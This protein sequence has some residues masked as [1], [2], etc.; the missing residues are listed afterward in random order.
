MRP[1]IA[2]SLAVILLFAAAVL[3]ESQQSAAA[4][5]NDLLIEARI[6]AERQEDNRVKVALELRRESADWTE[7]LQPQRRYLRADAPIDAWRYSEP[8]SP[9]DGVPGR[10]RIAAR[11]TLYGHVELALQRDLG[12][13]WGDLQLPRARQ[14]DSPRYG[15][16][17]FATSSIDLVDHG[18]Q[19]CRL[20][21]ILAPGDY[22]RFPDTRDLLV[23]QANGVARYPTSL[24]LPP[25]ARDDGRLA[26]GD[27]YPSAY[28]AVPF[29][30]GFPPGTTLQTVG[31][32][33]LGEGKYIIRR[34]G[35]DRLRP[36]NGAVCA[37]GLLIPFGH[38]CSVLAGYVW[39]V[40]YP[41]GPA[42]LTVPN[43][44]LHWISDTDLHAEVLPKHIDPHTVHAVR[45]TGGW[46]ITTLDAPLASSLPF[47]ATD[48][49]PCALG[50]IIAPGE[51]CS[52]P[53]SPSTFS[54]NADGYW[55][56]GNGPRGS[57]ADG[58][59]GIGLQ[60]HPANY[61]FGFRP[62]ADGRWL[63]VQTADTGGSLRHVAECRVG[64]VLY[65]GETCSSTGASWFEVFPDGLA[66]YH[67]VADRNRIHVE[68]V[69]KQFSGGVIASYDFTAERQDDGGFRIV[70]MNERL[71]QPET[72]PEP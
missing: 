27:P 62:L 32:D 66:A 45:E 17:R 42:H 30:H 3:H 8:L 61:S 38:Y 69:R 7:R 49:D 70:H 37:V 40:V 24:S 44:Q 23:I 1:R 16:N 56:W 43:D 34:L 31:I 57:P 48:V 67:R 52:D 46:R 50:A 4:Q 39:F 33:S 5:T 53:A 29:L 65:P 10:F 63:I 72:Q 55:R 35:R 36:V 58:G 6:T 68:D 71:I 11:R 14:L 47:A 59:S 54:V 9:I 25:G 51:S 13:G 12:D 28:F 15:P 41:Q 21:L 2:V 60:G 19:R 22:C 64:L 26:T 18:P 20:G